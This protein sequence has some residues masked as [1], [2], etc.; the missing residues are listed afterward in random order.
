MDDASRS[1]SF[2]ALCK[3]C[4]WEGCGVSVFCTMPDA[5]ESYGTVI[6]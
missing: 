3:Y 4:V 1:A 6:G 2:H 5:V